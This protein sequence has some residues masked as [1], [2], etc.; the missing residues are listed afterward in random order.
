MFS[1]IIDAVGEIR[2]CDRTA[3]GSLLVVRSP[4]YWTEIKPG[5][6]VAV[7]GACLTL[8]DADDRDGRF[9]VVA[10]TLRRTTLG[11][12]RTGG[13]V[14]LQKALRAGD[15][16]DGHFVQGHIDAI[17]AVMGIDEAGGE[18]VW[19][20]SVDAATR[21]LLVPK[22]SVAIDGISLTITKVRDDRFG[23]ALIP[24]TLEQTT[25]GQKRTGSRV[26]IETDIISRTVIQYLGLLS[27]SGGGPGRPGGMIDLLREHGFT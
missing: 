12:L 15:P 11:E 26:N 27:G 5:A 23:V 18:S 24:T 20:F 2:S 1:G 16:I 9:D 22:G 17:A 6:S 14:N 21:P 3:G 8:T 7:D 4:G 19:W 10:E 25:L 13:R